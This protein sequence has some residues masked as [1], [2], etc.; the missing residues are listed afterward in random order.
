MLITR[1]ATAGWLWNHCA[2]QF[3]IPRISFSCKISQGSNG[4]HCSSRMLFSCRCIVGE[5]D[6]ALYVAF[7]GTKQRR[8]LVANAQVMQDPVWPEDAAAFQ[9]TTSQ[10]HIF[11]H[12]PSATCP[13]SS[14]PFRLVATSNQAALGVWGPVAE[15]AGNFKDVILRLG[16][17]KDVPCA[18]SSS[19]PGLP[20][21]RAIRPH[22]EPL[23]ARLPPEEA[24]GA[25]R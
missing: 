6:G 4:L 7:M 8:D 19:T 23:R 14:A 16:G 18:G 2:S 20:D 13:W 17:E 11:L 12:V 24:P 10:A 15:Q 5:A 9:D 1:E 25:L 22:R 3:G 21:A